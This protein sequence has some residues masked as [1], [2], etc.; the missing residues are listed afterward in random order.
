MINE[1]GL[2]LFS[3]LT[4][5]S[6]KSIE[7]D[8][9][10]PKSNYE[11]FLKILFPAGFQRPNLT[12]LIGTNNEVKTA[13]LLHFIA[14]CLINSIATPSFDSIRSNNKHNP[15]KSPTL[16]RTNSDKR[17]SKSPTLELFKY[18]I[19]TSLSTFIYSS[20]YSE[21]FSII[22]IDTE[23]NF[24][25]H[26]LSHLIRLHYRQTYLD[27]TDYLKICFKNFH[28]YKCLTTS[29]LIPT[30]CLLTTSIFKHYPP[31]T[32][33][34]LIINSCTQ[35][36]IADRF[37]N[38]NSRTNII[39]EKTETF[40][41]LDKLTVQWQTKLLKLIEQYQLSCLLVEHTEHLSSLYKLFWKKHDKKF[42][43]KKDD[44]LNRFTFYNYQKNYFQPS[45]TTT[46]IH[47][48]KLEL[49]KILIEKPDNIERYSLLD[50]NHREIN[51]IYFMNDQII[52]S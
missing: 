36:A 19:D 1:S 9:Q 40:R 15:I 35:L 52:F 45:S 33:Y 34:L 23:N 10:Q 3:R 29:E 22:Y 43:S 12:E 13:F 41:E 24:S 38:V 8:I 16:T 20:S 51:Q 30:L 44:P 48:T 4:N 31:S 42:C 26:L 11:Y 17:R 14:S 37:I 47:N 49:K 2:A 6:T 7:N 18:Q 50:D 28:F 32:K 39:Y 21:R 5:S 46:I 25:I 27:E